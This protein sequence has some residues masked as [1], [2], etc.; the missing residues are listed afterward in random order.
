ME[1]IERESAESVFELRKDMEVD[2][3]TLRGV[4]SRSD[5]VYRYI[6]GLP[7][8]LVFWV[9]SKWW[10]YGYGVCFKSAD[11]VCFECNGIG[12]WFAPVAVAPACAS[13]P[14]RSKCLSSGIGRLARSVE[15][16]RANP[17]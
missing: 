5:T 12:I 6:L 15:Q 8:I 7:V 1:F 10:D 14:I 13:S 3:T 11:T 16:E 17:E 2:I 9:H 4:V